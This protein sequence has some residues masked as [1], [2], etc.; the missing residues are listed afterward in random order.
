[1]SSPMTTMITLD[2]LVTTITNQTKVIHGVSVAQEVGRHTHTQN[3]YICIYFFS[4][5]L[6]CYFIQAEPD[7]D[8]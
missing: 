2:G 6:H 3:I 4:T 1:M 5:L 8:M 7:S